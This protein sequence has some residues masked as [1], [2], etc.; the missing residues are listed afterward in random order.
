MDKTALAAGAGTFAAAVLAGTCVLAVLSAAWL[1]S[2]RRLVGREAHAALVGHVLL[3]LL[4]L[5]FVVS[6]DVLP[7]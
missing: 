1:R 3:A 4:C 7:V 5:V 2:T 6:H